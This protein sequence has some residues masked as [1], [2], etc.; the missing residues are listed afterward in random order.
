[1]RW[2]GFTKTSPNPEP[3]HRKQR[4][5]CFQSFSSSLSHYRFYLPFPSIATH[6]P[7]PIRHSFSWPSFSNPPSLDSLQRLFRR[8]GV[9][10]FQSVHHQTA[11]PKTQANARPGRSA[12][13][14]RHKPSFQH[15]VS[16]R[17]MPTRRCE[18][19]WW[20]W[21]VVRSRG[22]RGSE[23][24]KW[25]WYRVFPYGLFLVVS[26]FSNFSRIFLSS[27]QEILLV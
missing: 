25:L 17:P 8:S 19:A 14:W 9:Y 5:S 20:L 2:E 18:D 7:T 4:S 21:R 3:F 10:P 15:D 24:T 26:F 23:V 16:R 6:T 1:M 27:L 13:A 22:L 11:A 12:E